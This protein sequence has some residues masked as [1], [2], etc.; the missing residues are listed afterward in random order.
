MVFLHIQLVLALDGKNGDVLWHLKPNSITPDVP[1]LASIPVVDLYTVNG[2]R[3]LD[4]DSVSE[5]LA[6][7]VEEHRSTEQNTIAGHIT[8]ISGQTGKIIRT[9]PTPNHEELYVPIQIHTQIDGT[10]M[11]LVI[12]GGQ[13]SPGGVYLISLNTI[14]DRSKENTH[15]TVIHR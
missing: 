1:T 9:I 4:E 8:L 10:E 14:M 15:I 2:I 3:D 12:T 6:A 7:R 13:N 5:I 11:M